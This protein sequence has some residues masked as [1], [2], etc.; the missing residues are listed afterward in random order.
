MPDYPIVDAHV[1]LCDPARLGYGWMKHA[2]SLNRRVLPADVAQAATP[3]E[4][5]RFVFVEVDVDLPQHLDEAEWVAGLAA[6]DRRIAAMVASLRL[7]HGEAVSGE[8]DRLRR[9]TLL[10]GIRRLIQAETDP[11]F[12]IRPGFIAGLK[13]LAP[14]DLSFDICILHHQLPSVVRMVEQC[15]EVRFVLDHIG[16]PEI[17]SGLLDPWRRHLAELARLP[18]VFCK[19]SG[20]VTEADHANWTRDEVRPYIV[21]AIESF[22]FERVMYGGDWHVLGLAS[23]YPRWVEVVDWVVAGATAEE[24]RKLFRDNAIRFYRLDR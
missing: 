21:H 6:T 19:I 3:V 11:D 4:I 13:L 2:P 16:K 20:V 24:K 5:D 12:C 17:R 15:P 23:P 8:L 14:H 22:G 10:R 1:H 18:N 7:E 9:T